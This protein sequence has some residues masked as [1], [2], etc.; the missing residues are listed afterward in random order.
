MHYPQIRTHLH[1]VWHTCLVSLLLC[2]SLLPSCRPHRP[3]N[4][5]PCLFLSPCFSGLP[6]HRVPLYVCTHA[7]TRTHTYTF[8]LLGSITA[9]P[10]PFP[11]FNSL[12]PPSPGCSAK[13][14]A[15]FVY[16][17][18]LFSL[19]F[20]PSSAPALTVRAALASAASSPLPA[21]QTRRPTHRECGRAKDRVALPPPPP[22]SLLPFRLHLLALFGG[23]CVRVT[24]RNSARR[25]ASQR[26]VAALPTAR[27]ALPQ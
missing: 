21:S 11:W 3:I 6:P 23:R 7:R 5:P 2:F 25:C 15:V 4:R 24:E 18:A 27:S 20:S 26:Q 12:P 1:I 17:F 9:S 14:V 10:Y 16:T 8:S 13:S 19:S 22:P